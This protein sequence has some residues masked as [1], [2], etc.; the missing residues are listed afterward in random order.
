M[1][2]NGH[3]LDQVL[4][5]ENL[6]HAYKMGGG[7]Q[8]SMYHI[9]EWLYS[10]KNYFSQQMHLWF[11][12]ASC[13]KLQISIHSQKLSECPWAK[14][15]LVSVLLL[16]V[17]TKVSCEPQ[18]FK[19]SF[20]C[21]STLLLSLMGLTSLAFPNILTTLWEKRKNLKHLSLW[22]QLWAKKL[23]LG[24]TCLNSLTK[25]KII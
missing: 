1:K 10:V 13:Q 11:L 5:K 15:L 22:Q 12:E 19:I 16:Y 24:C 3:A 4:T 6:Y 14:G 7:S 23:I 9:Y 17:W 18:H 20:F 8:K 21:F 2:W 25:F